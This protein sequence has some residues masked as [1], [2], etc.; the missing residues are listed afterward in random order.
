MKTLTTERLII[1][2]FRKGDEDDIFAI[3]LD[4]EG[5][6]FCD[7]EE[8]FQPEDRYTEQY[9]EL[10]EAYAE[11]ESRLM[12]ELKEE[13]KVIGLLSAWK[14]DYRQVPTQTLV[15]QLHPDY[16]RKGYAT[17]AAKELIRYLFEETDTQLITAQ[18]V[19]Q[20]IPSIALL[21]KLGFVHEGTIR[22]KGFYPPVGIVDQEW[23]YLDKP[24]SPAT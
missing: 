17:E 4:K 9:A 11:Q 16:Q 12:L 21:R 20:N 6:Y 8:P 22:K 14:D 5:A 15:Y 18:A 13:N 7:G 10:M 1:R 2:P 19:P 23:F 3:L 24:D